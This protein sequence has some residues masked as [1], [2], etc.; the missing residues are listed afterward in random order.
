MELLMTFNSFNLSG[1]DDGTK[2]KRIKNIV[3]LFDRCV[4]KRATGEQCTRRK[5]EGEGYCGTHIKG[6][7]HGC[8]NETDETVVTNKK[9]EVWIQEIKGIVYY[10][11]A[12]KNVYDPEDILANKINPRIIMKLD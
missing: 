4:A 10:V 5:K 8:V 7:P 12:N 2:R 3:P 1:G 11:D 6:R 9:V